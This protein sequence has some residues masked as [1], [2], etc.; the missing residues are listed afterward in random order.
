MAAILPQGIA[1]DARLIGWLFGRML[2]RAF[3]ASLCRLLLYR[4][5]DVTPFGRAQQCL[6][7]II[8]RD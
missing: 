4:N 1:N 8:H 6:D 7:A 3:S 5:R 2:D